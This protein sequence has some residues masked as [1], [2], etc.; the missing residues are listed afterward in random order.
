MIHLAA[1][2]FFALAFVA[3]ATFLHMTIRTHWREIVLALKGELGAV[4][5]PAPRRWAPTPPR[6]HAAF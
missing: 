3:A 6:R 5:Q 2:L 1:A 4:R